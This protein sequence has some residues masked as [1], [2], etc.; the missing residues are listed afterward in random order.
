MFVKYFSKLRIDDSKKPNIYPFPEGSETKNPVFEK[1]QI[2]QRF[3][4]FGPIKKPSTFIRF[5]RF[6]ICTKF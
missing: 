2:F 6:F 5:F 3:Q 4:F 1:Q